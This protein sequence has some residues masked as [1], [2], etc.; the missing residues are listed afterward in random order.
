MRLLFILMS[1]SGHN[2]FDYCYPL[3]TFFFLLSVNA[4]KTEKK[5][6]KNSEHLEHSLDDNFK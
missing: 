6:K 3:T 2:E 5:E 1:V 4:H